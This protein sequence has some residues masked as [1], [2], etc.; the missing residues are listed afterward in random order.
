MDNALRQI[1]ESVAD[2]VD[3]T[4][5]SGSW[6]IGGRW[7]LGERLG[8]DAGEETTIEL[9]QPHVFER[10]SMDTEL[11]NDCARAGMESMGWIDGENLIV[12][13]KDGQVRICRDRCPIREGETVERI[14]EREYRCASTAQIL[15]SMMKEHPGVLAEPECTIRDTQRIWDI[16]TAALLAP[17]EA[18]QAA[19]TIP[20][21]EQRR[22]ATQLTDPMVLRA[23][24]RECARSDGYRIADGTMAQGTKIVR[25]LIRSACFDIEIEHDRAILMRIARKENTAYEVASET[26]QAG[27]PG[28]LAQRVERRGLKWLMD[29]NHESGVREKRWLTRILELG[30]V[31]RGTKSTPLFVVKYCRTVENAVMQG[32]GKEGIPAR[33]WT[34]TSPPADHDNGIQRK[35]EACIAQQREREREGIRAAAPGCGTGEQPGTRAATELDRAGRNSLPL[36]GDHE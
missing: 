22:I 3:R 17:D 26:L 35:L 9:E 30:D 12:A 20:V 1:I 32:F 14:G 11:L 18:V 16:A 4:K 33:R 5:A 25:D 36:T 15:G 34:R 7:M 31:P 2:A 19:S 10:L 13:T 21:H 6:R 24:T 23:Y 28:E 8:H 27:S 29:L